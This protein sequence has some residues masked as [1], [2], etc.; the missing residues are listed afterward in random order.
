[1]KPLTLLLFTALAIVGFPSMAADTE[2]VVKTM[3]LNGILNGKVSIDRLCGTYNV[4][5]EFPNNRFIRI[6]GLEVYVSRV[7]ISKGADNTLNISLQLPSWLKMPT[8]NDLQVSITGPK[9]TSMTLTNGSDIAV[10]GFYSAPQSL[11]L[12]VKGKSHLLFNNPIETSTVTATVSAGSTFIIN[13]VKSAEMNLTLNENSQGYIGG[14][15]MI[16]FLNINATGGSTAYTTNII[17]YKADFNA[18]DMSQIGYYV[19]PKSLVRHTTRGG[20]IKQSNDMPQVKGLF[21]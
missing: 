10:Q 3:K 21:K 14:A 11:C 9:L 5:E 15:S 17:V 12:N 1:M 4:D 8:Q 16:N 2:P 19:K 13:T 6:T 18:T 7:M 20:I